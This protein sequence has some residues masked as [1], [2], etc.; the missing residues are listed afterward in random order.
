MSEPQWTRRDPGTTSR[1]VPG[2]RP[3]SLMRLPGA[4]AGRFEVDGELPVQGA[5]SDLLLVHDQAGQYVV[6]MY[7]RGYSADREVW[8]TLPRL[9]S[10]HVVK[11]LET[12]HSDGRDYEIIEYLPEG[13]LRDLSGHR[14]IDVATAVGQLGDG[15][16]T[17]HAAGI[18]HRDLK[19]ENVLVRGAEL[20]ITDFGLSKV[21]EQSV[22]FASSSRTL[23]YAAPESLSGQVSPARDWWS[24]GMIARE[25]ATGRRPFE[26]MSETVVVDH[27]ATRPIS[28][29]D[30]TDPRL[31]MLCRGLLTRDPRHRW[32]HPQVSAWLRGESPPVHLDPPEPARPAPTRPAPARPSTARPA[33][34]PAGRD[35]GIGDAVAAEVREQ[36]AAYRAQARQELWDERERTRRAGAG[37]ARVRAVLWSLGFLAFWAAGAF[38]IAS[39]F[40]GTTGGTTGV[41]GVQRASAVPLGLLL[42]IAGAAWLVSCA[43]EV[44]VASRQGADYLREGPW[45]AFATAGRLLSGGLSKTSR[46]MSG[47]ARRTGPRGCGVALV[48]ATI[49]LLM[50]LL[51]V[52]VLSALAWMLWFL[53]VVAGTAGHV[54]AAGVRTHH[55]NKDLAARRA[56][57]FE[58]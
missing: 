26:G 1:D 55:W 56:E 52:S 48:A 30:I 50:L 10:P 39:M 27:L 49:P 47:T 24:L 25:L 40:S 4:L 51:L 35:E 12:G 8:A 20:V 46:A 33:P 29:D 53:L 5:E 42:L 34:V 2:P 36:E 16:R 58:N 3:E 38:A 7:R 31:R 44:L 21:L 28:N 19:P 18:V 14:R 41:G 57:A 32:A 6:K 54:I 13:N 15:L 37:R 22:V 11:V 23:A 43:T 45:A 9:T 17:L